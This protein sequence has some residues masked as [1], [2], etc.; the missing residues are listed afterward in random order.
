MELYGL[1][2]DL[3]T[4]YR[5]FKCNL[6]ENKSFFNVLYLKLSHVTQI[7]CGYIDEC[8]SFSNAT[9]LEPRCW[10]SI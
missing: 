8:N 10:E 9:V 2:G 1:R 4:V 3:R 5:A 7:F 6:S